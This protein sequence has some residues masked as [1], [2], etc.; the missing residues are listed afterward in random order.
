MSYVDDFHKE[1][2]KRD[3]SKCLIL[4]EEYC[5]GDQ[6]DPQEFSQIAK[7]LK[8]S[9]FAKK[10]GELV[11]DILPLWASIS[12]PEDSY[13]VL[14]AIV[15]LQSINTPDLANLAMDAL[16]KKYSSQPNFLDR[17]RLVG[18]RDRQA[19]QGA[20][21]NYELLCHMSKGNFVFH[22]SGWGVGEILDIS[23]IRE[24][25]TIEFEQVSG[26]RDISFINAFKTLIP[27]PAE[28]FYSRRFGDPDKFEEEARAKPLEVIHVLLRDLGPQN[29]SEIKDAL[30]DYV[31]PEKDWSRW[32]TSTRQK[33]KKDTFV[34][35]P[36]N[37]KGSF[38]LRETEMTQE[39]RM[40]KAI[41]TKT[42][43]DE[44]IL[45]TYNY[46]RD[47]AEAAKSPEIRKELISK[48]TSLLKNSS[49]KLSPEQK[50]Q[51]ILC[52]EQFFN[53]EEPEFSSKKFLET[54]EN[55]DFIINQMEIIALKKRALI[56]VKQNK[57]DWISHFQSILFSSQQTPIKD[58]LLGE[59]NNDLARQELEKKLHFLLKHPKED[60]DTF[61]WYF[62]KLVGKETKKEKIPFQDKEG[63]CLFFESFFI[64]LHA[65]EFQPSQKDN[66]KKMMNLLTAKRYEL[67]RDIFQG[68]SIDYI[69]EILLLASKCQT[70]TDQD[71]KILRSLA[72]V[73]HP[74][75]QGNKEKK[76]ARK[77]PHIIWTTERGYRQTQERV[78]HIGTIEVIDNAKEIEAA[79]ALGDLRE[80]SEY[81]FALERRSRLQSELKMLSEQLNKARII[82]K[83]DIRPGEIDVGTIIEIFDANENLQV[84]TIL[85]PWDADPE[86]NILSF[87]SQFAQ[88]MIGY[89][90]GD[91]F[92]FKDDQYKIGKIK[93]IFE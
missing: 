71:K 63:Q 32:W 76:N 16:K 2:I 22:T 78:K 39:E 28:H 8:S 30:C 21:S 41:H 80:N 69:K 18:L 36:E 47:N 72:E 73:V 24:H 10:F 75:I 13:Q 38:R 55:I 88:A 5:K 9:D 42:G 91:L 70:I 43:T 81:K 50:L 65:I 58:Y 59:L 44:I 52:L 40:K 48:L 23:P 35:S 15:D 64:L 34:E 6:I 74:S 79:R 49:L 17:L 93:T 57:K 89:K 31:I 11:V 14:K 3:L 7:I 61:L 20:I 62:Q 45:N 29:A 60:P 83:E 87:Q 4:W 77:E 37:L 85:G 67:V 84:Y 90:K 25:L 51:I 82:T 12:N 26:K 54:N 1:V 68:T 19:F 27:L 46:I 92:T 53:H 33:L 86:K 66:V 56:L